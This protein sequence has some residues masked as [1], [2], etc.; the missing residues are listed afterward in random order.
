MSTA[1]KI[2]DDGASRLHEPVMAA[3]V[4]ELLAAH[5]PSVIVDATVGAGGHAAKLLEATDARLLG[6]DRDASAL[7]VAAERLSKFGPR[8]TLRHADFAELDTI[9]DGELIEQADA[10]LADLGM[11]SFA[12]DDP[13]RGFSFRFDAPLDMRMD[14]RQTLRAYDLVNEEGEAELAR[15]IYTYGEE[16][17]SRRIARAIVEARRRRPIETTGELRVVIE[18]VLGSRRRGR[19]HPATRTFQALRIVVNH[20][21]ESLGALL[22]CAPMRLGGGGRIVVIAY[23]SLEDRAVK[24]RF[25]ELVGGGG[26]VPVTGKVVRPSAGEVARNPRARSARLR[27]VERGG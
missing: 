15:L 21:L 10:I 25:R 13:A 19:I 7:A 20:E 2:D 26:F 8:V 9:L 17:A 22:K 4:C 6:I 3:Q 18:G 24:E 23:H 1:V 5:R 11:S 14:T 27:C 12:L 16:R